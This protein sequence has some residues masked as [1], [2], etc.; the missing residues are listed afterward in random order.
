MIDQKA[1]EI[2]A[3]LHPTGRVI[4]ADA[5]RIS[6]GIIEGLEMAAKVVEN[7]PPMF[8]AQDAINAIRA[9]IEESKG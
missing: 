4:V 8:S 5:T 6:I 7:L 9:L 3:S 1:R 2:A